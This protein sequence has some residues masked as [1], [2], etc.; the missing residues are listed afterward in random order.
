[1]YRS[2]ASSGSVEIGGQLVVVDPALAV[3]FEY[4]GISRGIGGDLID[5]RIAQFS[6]ERLIRIKDRRYG[7][8]NHLGTRRDGA[9]RT[10]Y[11]RPAAA[12]G[13]HVAIDVDFA[14]CGLD[15]VNAVP[16]QSRIGI[17]SG[18]GIPIPV[19][20]GRERVVRPFPP[21]TVGN[22]IGE[23][24]RTNDVPRSV[25]PRDVLSG[26]AI[27]RGRLRFEVVDIVH[28]GVPSLRGKPASGRDLRHGSVPCSVGYRENEYRSKKREGRMEGFSK[29]SGT[30]V[31][32]GKDGKNTANLKNERRKYST[33]VLISQK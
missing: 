26:R 21:R 17:I 2:E 7:R 24:T 1:M 28:E 15:G 4:G 31:E 11:E 13:S 6:N 32:H 16:G 33:T 10:G 18:G 25:E 23:R 3:L 5:D 19:A 27:D 14:S 29:M 30:R 22:D 20:T 8:G 9:Y 12:V